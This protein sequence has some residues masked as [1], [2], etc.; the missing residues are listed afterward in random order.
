MRSKRPARRPQ[1]DSTF[2]WERLARPRVIFSALAL[3]TLLFYWQPLFSSATSIQWDAVDVQYSPQKHLADSFHEGKLPFWS[4]YVYSGMPFLADPQL[5]AWYPLNWPFFL[6]GITPRAIEAQLALH[7]LIAAIGAYLLA[8]EF[9][10]SRTACILAALFFAFSGFFAGHSSH[11]GIFQAASWLPALLWTSRRAARSWG[12]LSPLAIVSG[13]IVLTGHFQTALYSFFALAV[14]LAVDLA[15]ARRDWRRSAAALVCSA[16]ASAAL[17]AV[18]VLPGLEL[19]G[20]SIR[21]GADYSHDPGATLVPGALATLVAPDHYGALDVEHYTGPQDVTQFYLYMGILLL[22]FAAWGIASRDRRPRAIVG[23]ALAMAGA[24]YAFGPSGGLYSAIAL[25]SG[26]RSVR[27]PVHIWFVAALGLALLAGV[28]VDRI[29]ARWK[30][31]W[32]ALALIVFTTADLYYFNMDRNHLAYARASFQD[33]YGA[34]QDRFRAAVAPIA[35]QPMHR[36]YAPDKSPSFGPL[37]GTLDSRIEVTFGY[38]PLELS[39]YAQYLEAAAGNPRLL[40][41]LGVT[42]IID[43]ARGSMQ[44][45]PAALPR[46]HAPET[47]SAVRSRDEARARLASLDPAH[48]AIVEGLAPIPQ[49]GGVQVRMTAYEGDTYRARVEA[50]HAALL[51]IAVPYFPGWQAEIDGAPARIAPA[52]LA[53]IG[54]MVPAGAHE[55]KLHYRSTW[56][57]AGLAMS[58]AGWAAALWGLRFLSAS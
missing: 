17:P 30:S 20:Q 36:I 3:T 29:R 56:W 32:I 42:A 6:L 28:G 19:S 21:A 18:M 24:W 53:L 9:A 25:L 48:E 4:P 5:G 10:A 34:S 51:R 50:P 1:A 57:L 58:I 35:A 40:N 2:S 16:M 45:N 22:P 43:P 41:G 12:W 54:V 37:N 47:V 44:S 46:I 52:D 27:A 8:R 26:F 14:F 49:N 31:P 13:L 38:N 23:I 15:I 55:L 11:V 39:R 7:A 33:L